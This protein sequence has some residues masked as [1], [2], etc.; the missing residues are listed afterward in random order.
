MFVSFE[1]LTVFFC[2][3]VGYSA[4]KIRKLPAEH[5]SW[6]VVN[7]LL[8][9]YIFESVTTGP[10]PDSSSLFFMAGGAAFVIL[11]SFTL[12]KIFERS[13]DLHLGGAVLPLL[14]MNSGYLGFPLTES[15][16]GKENV[17]HAVIFDQANSLLAFTLG[18]AIAGGSLSPK[19]RI[20]IALLNPIIVTLAIAVIVR[21]FSIPVPNLLQSFFSYPASATLPMALITLG[22]GLSTIHFQGLPLMLAGT[23]TRFFFGLFAGG[24]FIVLFSPPPDLSG[25]ILLLASGPSA[26]MSYLIAEEYST[27][28]NFS[29]G[30][31]LIST[32]LYP[33][34]LF[35]L[36]EFGFFGQ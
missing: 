7:V 9:F 24:L 27:E 4:G 32:L 13:L 33:I 23:L 19:Q 16:F 34:L 10:L 25:I 31:V 21:S 2:L 3:A 14:F 11:A 17:L 18:I 22:I 15:L 8:P 1:W 30:T 35:F 26:V 12:V 36:V 5:L 6:L 20:R 28:G 29:A